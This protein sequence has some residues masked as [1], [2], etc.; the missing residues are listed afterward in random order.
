MALP[1]ACLIYFRKYECSFG[2]EI[3]DYVE[4]QTV[5]GT[6]TKLVKCS[7]PGVL[8][9]SEPADY[10]FMDKMKDAGASQFPELR[11]LM[12]EYG[13]YIIDNSVSSLEYMDESRAAGSAGEDGGSLSVA[14]NA[15]VRSSLST[16]TM[17][18]GFS[19][20]NTNLL[21]NKSVQSIALQSGVGT[22]AFASGVSMLDGR[23]ISVSV[24]EQDG[25]LR[26]TTGTI[27]ASD[28]EYKRKNMEALYNFYINKDITSLLS[29]F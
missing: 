19:Y 13:D 4:G 28:Y 23:T 20:C 17:S 12:C 14:M 22:F 25:V 15:E 21:S 26:V 5:C 1:T 11:D 8:L 18:S 7:T 6:D 10:L 29:S 16:N 2:G 24:Y 27:T 3:A 9:Y